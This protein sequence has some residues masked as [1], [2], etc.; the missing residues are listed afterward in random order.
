MLMLYFFPGERDL[1]C[2]TVSFK[3]IRSL[4]SSC[5][6]PSAPYVLIQ[7]V[8]GEAVNQSQACN[9]PPPPPRTISIIKSHK[10]SHCRIIRLSADTS[11]PIMYAPA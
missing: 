6:A 3:P 7:E 11:E 8:L 9:P 10:I 5:P 4:K 2:C 1:N